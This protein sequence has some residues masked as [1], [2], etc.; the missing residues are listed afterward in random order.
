MTYI[1]NILQNKYQVVIDNKNPD[2]VFWTNIYSSTDVVDT[3][4]NELGSTHTQFPQA[5]KIFLSCEA[6]NNHLYIVEH[7]DKHFAI[8]PEPISHEK[9]LQLPIHNT[10]SA[11]GLYDESKFFNHPYNWLT[12]IKDGEKILKEKKH[13]CG[14]VQNSIVPERVELFNKLSNYKFV[15]ASGGWITNVPPEEATIIYPRI[16][17]E[18]YLS[19]INFLK[20]C[21]FS[22]QVQ[23]NIVRHLTV[24]KLIQAFAAQTIPIY[25]GNDLVLNDGFN[26]KSFINC[27]DFSS[28]DDVV[29]YV[30]EIDNNDKLFQTIVSEP[31]FIN[32]QLP[33]YFDSSY[34]LNFLDKIINN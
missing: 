25:Y 18:G 20:E 12:E 3:F 19:K 17:G 16:D 5:K 11:W 10:T 31:I 29:E 23:S 2:L 4:T 14:V 32:N 24:E 33:Y 1:I 9:Y 30:K 21:K 34:V 8:G 7:D 28:F 15:R 22:I 27:H 13:F 26:P 6:C